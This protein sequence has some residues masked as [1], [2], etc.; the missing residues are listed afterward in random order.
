[1]DAESWAFNSDGVIRHN[2][3]ELHKVPNL[4]QEGDIIVRWK[5]LLR[6][7]HSENNYLSHGFCIDF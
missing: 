5:T 7:N 4:A 6:K 2:K 1:M 3:E